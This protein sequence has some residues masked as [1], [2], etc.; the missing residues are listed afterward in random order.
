MQ[1]ICTRFYHCGNV[2]YQP[3]QIITIEDEE[4]A[5]WLIRDS[6][7]GIELFV[8]KPPEEARLVEAPPQDRMVKRGRKR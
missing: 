8:E 1:L 7:G 5:S 6:A 2:T 3:G 4:H